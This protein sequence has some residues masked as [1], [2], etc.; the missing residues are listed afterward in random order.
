MKAL[1]YFSTNKVL[2]GYLKPSCQFIDQVVQENYGGFKFNQ[3]IYLADFGGC[4][5]LDQFGRLS[6]ILEQISS[7]LGS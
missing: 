2:K 4:L 3:R 1:N 5:T 6:N 7:V